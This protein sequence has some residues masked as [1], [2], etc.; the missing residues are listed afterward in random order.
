MTEPCIR[1]AWLTLGA[2]TVYLE[3]RALGY[4]CSKLDLGYPAVREVVNNRPDMDGVDDRTTLMASRV[5]SADITALAGA[6]AQV[7]QVAASF[8]PFMVPS[9]RPVLHYILDRPGTAERILTLRAAAYTWPIVGPFERDIQLQWVA[10]DPIVRDPAAHTVAARSGASTPIG[11]TYPLTFN[12][13]YPPGSSTP[14]TAV[15]ASP[16]DVAV[17]PLLRIYGPV[18]APHVR[19][20]LQPDGTSSQINFAQSFVVDAGHW[21]DI[22]GLNHT[23][24]RDSDPAQS[25]LSSVDWSVSSWPYIPPLPQSAILS[26]SGQSTSAVSQVQATWNDGYLT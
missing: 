22:D 25:V 10:A 5:V 12:R 14:S 16:G 6:G 23:V 2:L 8:A 18:T 26:M 21:V 17:R 15:I 1:Q 19:L 3:N 4:F 20:Q 9:A 11:R 7:D 24:R 13:V